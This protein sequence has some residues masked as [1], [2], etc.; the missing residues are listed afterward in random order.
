MRTHSHTQSTPVVLLVVMVCACLLLPSCA[1]MRHPAE[2]A[3]PAVPADLILRLSSK[4]E[5]GRRTGCETVNVTVSDQRSVAGRL[6]ER[7]EQRML[8]QGFTLTDKPSEAQRIVTVI[9]LYRGKGSLEE[10]EKT[11]SSGYN[12]SVSSM[13]AQGAVLVTDLLLIRRRV[14]ATKKHLSNVSAHNALSSSQVRI[15]LYSN[16]LAV[17]RDRGLE[18]A[19]AREI[20]SLA[21][22]GDMQMHTPSSLTPTRKA[23]TKKKNS[24]TRSSSKARASKKSSNTQKKATTGRAKGTGT[25]KAGAKSKNTET[26]KDGT[27]RSGTRT[28][29]TRDKGK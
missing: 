20:A 22:Y 5:H 12:T 18:E 25:Q 9:V 21:V 13:H 15:G 16:E 2:S 26:R 27:A 24:R 7:L 11:V 1:S 3:H 19:L 29:V 6:K 23:F 4:L 14:P 8:S 10:M 17:L 28:K